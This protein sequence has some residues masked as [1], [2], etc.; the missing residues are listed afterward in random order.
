M[1]SGTLIDDDQ[2]KHYHI[3]FTDNRFGEIIFVLKPGGTFFPN[4]F[5]PFKA[6]KGLHGYLPDESVQDSFLISN[7]K[8]PIQ[9]THVKDIKE[10]MLSCFSEN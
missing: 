7:K 8:P 2:R 5:S 9:L 10:L 4:F 1:K 6:M 3:N